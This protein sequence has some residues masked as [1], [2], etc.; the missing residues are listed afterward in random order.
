[1]PKTIIREFDN[2]TTGIPLA[3]NFSV[4]VPGFC[5]R[6]KA[7]INGTKTAADVLAEAIKSGIYYN[8]S[9][10][11]VLTSQKQFLEYIGKFAVEEGQTEEGPE[12]EVM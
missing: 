4:L 3:V 11:Y 8:D 7:V 6:P 1:M 12:L 9:K 5:G 10:T 2:S